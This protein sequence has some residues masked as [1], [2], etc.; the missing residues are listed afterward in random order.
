MLDRHHQDARA[1]LA[2]RKL[3]R[4]LS[5]LAGEIGEAT[6]LRSLMIGGHS[7]PEAREE[8]RKLQEQELG[9]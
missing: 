1:E 4:D 5:F 8:L 9:L 7:L 3:A 6:Y 2:E